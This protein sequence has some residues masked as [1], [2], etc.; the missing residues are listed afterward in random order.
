M[1]LVNGGICST[2]TI[3]VLH[4]D[5]GSFASVRKFAEG[6]KRI[7]PTVD[8]LIN[9]AAMGSKYIP[10][11]S[12]PCLQTDHRLDSSVCRSEMLNLTR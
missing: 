8:V 7:S 10:S 6:I 4:L 3:H 2:G 9:N 5:L 1:E 11:A 12:L